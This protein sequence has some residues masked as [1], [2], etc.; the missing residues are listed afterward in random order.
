MAKIKFKV[1]D[2]D[3]RV[4]FVNDRFIAVEKKD[5]NVRLL[6]IIFDENGLP[7]IDTE[8]EV[9]ITRGS[10]VVES[11]TIDDNGEEIQITTF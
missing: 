8:N 11:S 5:N 9:L 4:L 3:E 10:N 7:R 6:P 2:R 1:L